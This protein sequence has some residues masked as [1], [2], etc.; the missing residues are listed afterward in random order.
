MLTVIGSAAAVGVDGFPVTV[1]CNTSDKLPYF[2]IVGLPDNAVKESKERVKNAIINSGYSFFD[3]EIIINMAPA[4]IKKEGSSFDLSF[5]VGI[6]CG[7]H[8]IPVKSTEGSCF[9]GELSLSGELRPV[10]GVLCMC[11]AAKKAGMKSIFVPEANA[12]EASVVDGIDVYSVK[13]LDTLISH[14]RGER[15]LSPVLFDRSEF[16]VKSAESD[17]DFAD[18]KGQRRVKRAVEIACAGGHN[19]LLIGPPGT[20]KSMIAKRIPTILPPLTFE[21]AVETTKLHSIA[22]M[23]GEG[24]SLVTHRPFRS[25]HHTLSPIALAGGGTNPMPGEISL[26]HNGVLFLDELP[27]FTR[28]AM[29][30]LRQPIEDGVITITRASGRVTYPS[31]FM[32]ICAMNPCKCGFR[33]HPTKKCTCTDAEVKRYISKISGPLLDRIDIQIEVPSLEFEEISD[34]SKSEETS[35]A[36]RER[37]TA[38]RERANAR[39]QRDGAGIYSNAALTHA[40]LEKYCAPDRDGEILLRSVFNSMGLSARG[41]DRILKVAR[42]IADLDDSDEIK[43]THIAEAVQLRTLDRK[44][45]SRQ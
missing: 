13:S 19:I 37:V 26:A 29:E 21:E 4:D 22:G 2:E 30:V 24:E 35:G 23:L 33:G 8:V 25:P 28:T 43:S 27:E 12:A 36:I 18:V 39:Y 7:M 17:V 34:R 20:G 40:M 31:D 41:Y 6:L 5:A 10:R 42:T 1:E 38:A 11:I 14:L 45:F 32:L 15:K 44:Y 16:T 9:L 3:G